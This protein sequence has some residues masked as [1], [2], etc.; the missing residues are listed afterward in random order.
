[1]KTSNKLNVVGEDETRF[2]DVLHAVSAEKKCNQY[3][4]A[5]RTGYSQAAISRVET[6]GRSLS[7]KL[8]AKLAEVLGGDAERWLRIYEQT[9]AGSKLP[10]SF[11][12]NELLGRDADDDLPGAR[13]R[14]MQK[15]DIIRIFS[16]PGGVMVFRGIE[17][18]CEI[19]NFS[20]DYVQLTSYDTRVG[21]YFEPEDT[22]E[23]C[24]VEVKDQLVIPA[25]SVRRVIAREHIQ[26]P[27][28]L[29]A[30]INP[31]SNIGRKGLFVSN[32][33]IID[34]K[35]SGYLTVSVLNPTTADIVLSVNEPFLT[36]R[37]WMQETHQ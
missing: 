31:A 22:K 6:G 23:E 30:D 10:V 26:L 34:P 8:A 21:G 12:R 17:E 15:D 37:F 36:L 32:G 13:I 33:P 19:E 28:W 14:R 5:T 2:G 7:P 9:K 16:N 4:L 1:M 24:P 18:E 20:E 25:T 3:Q 11:Y 29:E 27:S 35:W